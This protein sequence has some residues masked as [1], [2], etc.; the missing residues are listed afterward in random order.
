MEFNLPKIIA[1][2]SCNN[3][4]QDV[5][6]KNY[7]LRGIFQGF[8][9]PG[10]PLGAEFMTFTRFYYEGVGEFQIDISLYNE[11]GEKVSD[12]QPRKLQFGSETPVHD[13][14]TAW[15]ILFPAPGVYLF[16]VFCNNLNLNEYK[17]FC[18]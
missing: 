16:K 6:S 11:K 12:T 4:Q 5:L 8:S 9:P 10:Y 1:F 17:I 14:I 7:E 3:I 15:R 2:L 13:L 18:R